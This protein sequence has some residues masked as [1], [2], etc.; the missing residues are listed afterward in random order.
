MDAEIKYQYT[1][2]QL[3][4]VMRSWGVSEPVPATGK[5]VLVSFPDEVLDNAVITLTNNKSPEGE[6]LYEVV[7][8]SSADSLVSGHAADP[9]LDRLR[10]GGHW[11]DYTILRGVD[12]HAQQ[13]P[14]ALSPKAQL[15]YDSTMQAM[16]PAEE[17]GGPEGHDYI[18][19]LTAIRN[20]AAKRLMSFLDW[21][22]SS[23]TDLHQE[24]SNDERAARIDTLMGSY[25]E[26]R[27]ETPTE[28]DEFEMA[29]FVT[30][31]RHWCDKHKVSF[32]RVVELSNTNYLQELPPGENPAPAGQRNKP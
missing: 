19:L 23:N 20:E 6:P 26:M 12:V 11:G 30:D 27:G 15:I 18:N 1:R 5:R 14:A 31:V 32:D 25:A 24:P 22:R 10:I 29:S 16:Q 3:Q 13:S 28:A 2:K 17:L 21:W 4:M 8:S 9:D 7:M